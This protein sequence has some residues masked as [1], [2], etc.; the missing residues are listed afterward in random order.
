MELTNIF[1]YVSYGLV[2]VSALIIALFFFTGAVGE[3]F[4]L[5]WTYI[6][7][8]VACVA[9]IGFAIWGMIINSK[10][11]V[12]VLIGIVALVVVLTISYIAA[13]DAIPVFLGY[14]KFNI[15]PALSKTVGGS[16][17]AI[18]ALLFIAI[19]GIVYSELSKALK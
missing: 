18:Y 1:K 16:L 7:T 11:A 13:S 14:E 17:Y 10:N 2:G 6:L 8:G 5:T 9:T 3:D 4:Y 19:V 15:T 12:N